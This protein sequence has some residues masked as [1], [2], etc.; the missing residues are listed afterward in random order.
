MKVNYNCFECNILLTDKEMTEWYDTGDYCCDG[1]MCGCRG[2][3][4][5]PPICDNCGQSIEHTD[6]NKVITCCGTYYIP[7]DMIYFVCK[8][9]KEFKIDINGVARPM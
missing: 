1:N 8:C 4:T 2:E 9:S 3:P 7:K 5:N 6:R